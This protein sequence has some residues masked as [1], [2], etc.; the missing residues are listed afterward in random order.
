MYKANV[1]SSSLVNQPTCVW[2]KTRQFIAYR[3]RF[4]RSGGCDWITSA[5]QRWLP[6][7]SSTAQDWPNWGAGICC[8]TGSP[9]SLCPSRAIPR[10]TCVDIG[11]YRPQWPLLRSRNTA[12][13]RARTNKIRG[14]GTCAWNKKEKRWKLIVKTKSFSHL[15]VSRLFHPQ[16]LHPQVLSHDGEQRD[17][18]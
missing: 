4:H 16:L 14:L 2:Y 7:E 18:H 11:S 1:H 3:L 15:V 13:D 17:G 12:L 6:R 10:R 9:A 5:C 8:V